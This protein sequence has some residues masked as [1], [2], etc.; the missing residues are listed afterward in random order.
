MMTNRCTKRLNRRP[1]AGIVNRNRPLTGAGSTAPC[2]GI[3]DS[4]NH[5]PTAYSAVGRC[6]YPVAWLPADH[7]ALPQA[8]RPGIEP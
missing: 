7:P 5:R 3:A 8:P 6:A 4:G 2:G 1:R